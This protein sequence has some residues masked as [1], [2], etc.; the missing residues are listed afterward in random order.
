MFASPHSTVISTDTSG[1]VRSYPWR[2][3][4]PLAPDRRAVVINAM[5]RSNVMPEVS[6]MIQVSIPG[7]LVLNPLLM[8]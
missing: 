1:L 6:D 3:Q 4:V 2:T 5:D 7:L 8:Q